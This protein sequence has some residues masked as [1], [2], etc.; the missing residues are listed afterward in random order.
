MTINADKAWQTIQGFG[1][2]CN[3]VN[4][5]RY[6]YRQETHFINEVAAFIYTF[7]ILVLAQSVNVTACDDE[8]Q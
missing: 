6:L 3:L 2:P 1:W 7:A 8:S 5:W 4:P